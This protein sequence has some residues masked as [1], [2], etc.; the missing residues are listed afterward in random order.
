MLD[1]IGIQLERKRFRAFKMLNANFKI[2]RI[3]DYGLEFV[4]STVL[5][6]CFDMRDDIQHKNLFEND[7]K[8]FILW[9]K[10]IYF[11]AYFL[12]ACIKMYCLCRH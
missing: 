11:L 4:Y 1:S 6:K 5:W 8:N 7:A 2:A 10:K 3:S 12:A 9:D